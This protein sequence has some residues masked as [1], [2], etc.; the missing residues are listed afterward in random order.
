MAFDAKQA[1]IEKLTH[2]DDQLKQ[3]KAKQ[4][5]DAQENALAV[6]VLEDEIA[7][8]QEFLSAKPAAGGVEKPEAKKTA[9][10]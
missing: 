3:A 10:K 1:V 5:A 7:G 6:A 2:L 8:W 9:K 4:E